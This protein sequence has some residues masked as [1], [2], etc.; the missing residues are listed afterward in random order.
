[1][2][3]NSLNK[4]YSQVLEEN[5]IRAKL[6]YEKNKEMCKKK[7][8]ERYNKLKNKYENKSV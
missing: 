1:M 7:A 4:S 5:R 8:L 3:R 2:G 6:Y